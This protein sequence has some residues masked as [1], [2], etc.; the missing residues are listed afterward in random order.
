MTTLATNTLTNVV[1]ASRCDWSVAETYTYDNYYEKVW[2]A[3]FQI[4]EG[5]LAVV[6]GGIVGVGLLH[7]CENVRQ[8]P[9]M[10]STL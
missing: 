10:G 9:T 4:D 8:I 5:I 1:S 7:F 6:D 3:E 2:T